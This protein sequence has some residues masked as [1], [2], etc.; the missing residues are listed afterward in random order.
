MQQGTHTLS[1]LY[2][3]ATKGVSLVPAAYYADL[4]CERGRL[5]LNEFLNTGIEKSDAGKGKKDKVAVQ[6]EVYDA[7][8]KSWGSGVHERLKNSMFYI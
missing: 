3:R 7:C 5:Y 4:A 2:A 8:V 1:Y 6:K